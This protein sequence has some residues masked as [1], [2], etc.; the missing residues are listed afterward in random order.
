MEVLPC[1]R[2]Y[3]GFMPRCANEKEKEKGSGLFDCGRDPLQ[4]LHV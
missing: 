2:N 4:P 1:L 3:F